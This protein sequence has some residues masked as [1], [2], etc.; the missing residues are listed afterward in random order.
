MISNRR[1]PTVLRASGGYRAIVPGKPHE[2][3][4]IERIT[5]QDPDERMP[6]VESGNIKRLSAGEIE[7]FC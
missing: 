6:P 5:S 1:W 7:I 3:H 4:L 2:S